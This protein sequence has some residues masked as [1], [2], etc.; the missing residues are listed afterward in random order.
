[1]EMKMEKEMFGGRCKLGPR[2]KGRKVKGKRKPQAVRNA[3]KRRNALLQ[4][5][6]CKAA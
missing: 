5:L 6:Q 1:M 2:E 4:S 3:R